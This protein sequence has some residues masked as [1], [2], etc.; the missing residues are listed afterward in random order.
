MREN[1]MLRK[2]NYDTWN[3]MRNRC[4]NP[5]NPYYKN[6]GERGIK[7]CDRWL[8]PIKVTRKGKGSLPTQGFLN[9]LEDMGETW[10]PGATIDRIDNDGDYTPENC[11]WLSKSD[12]VKKEVQELIQNKTHNFLGGK[13]SR[14]RVANGTHNFLDGES[15][16]E[17][18]LNRVKNGTHNFIINH[19]SLGTM[20]ITNGSTNRRILKD[21]QIPEGWKRGRTL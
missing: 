21:S 20:Y 13:L 19:P 1:N 14:E 2:K 9:F 6:Y 17:R 11:Q 3:S 16:R 7:V 8:D 5:N 12:N 10:F 18:A 4:N 15:Q